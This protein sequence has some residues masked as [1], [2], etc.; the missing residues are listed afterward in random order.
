MSP[1]TVAMATSKRGRPGKFSSAPADWS[2]SEAYRAQG[3]L[4][5]AA[6]TGSANG[7]ARGGGLVVILADS[8]I[9][10]EGDIRVDGSTGQTGGSGG[11][12][13][14]LADSRDVHAS[15]VFSARG[16][17]GVT[18]GG[19]AGG[20][21][22]IDGHAVAVRGAVDL[23][24]GPSTSSPAGSGGSF[25]VDAADAIHLSFSEADLSG[26]GSHSAGGPGG[27]L[28]LTAG[29]SI[30]C[31][32]SIDLSGGSGASGGRGGRAEPKL[33]NLGV[34][35]NACDMTANG[36]NG[37]TGPGG[38]GGA[39]RFTVASELYSDSALS[40]SGGGSIESDA[41]DGGEVT[42]V[43]NGSAE[44]TARFEISG[45]VEANGG[46]AL[47]DSARGGAG[48]LVAIPLFNNG[49][50]GFEV[51]L[52]GY[53]RIDLSGG[54]GSSVGGN[55]GVL[56]INNGLF[57]E[58]PTEDARFGDRGVI[59]YV[60][61]L[62][63]GGAGG[64]GVG[65]DGGTFVVRTAPLGGSSAATALYNYGN[66]ELRG[67]AG[68]SVGGQGG[69]FLVNTA[70]GIFFLG[71]IVT[72]GGDSAGEGGDGSER[73][74]LSTRGPIFFKGGMQSRGGHSLHGDAPAGIGGHLALV[75]SEAVELS[76]GADLSG[77]DNMARLG[78][79]GSGGTFIVFVP[80]KDSMLMGRSVD[81][82]GGL[83]LTEGP[84]GKFHFNDLSILIPEELA[85]T[86]QI[87]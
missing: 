1:Q 87:N 70:D 42:F 77:G 39:L 65:G 31:E 28:E 48:G 40:A 85:M 27:R 16:G 52:L 47:A 50:D 23:V 41:G 53:D 80:S 44:S 51:R 54:D 84:A 12:I 45:D 18:G 4:S 2:P 79:G 21:V 59:S 35:R 66:W 75:S 56:D 26:G 24:G 9:R 49:T 25:R 67:G 73:S 37:A 60:D 57:E 62:A 58:D 76:E 78:E 34:L 43:T 68:E 11:L 13:Q 14:L 29:S 55:G 32:G 38:Q 63:N 5:A 10:H 74:E 15:G 19:G 71:D 69:A 72:S 6:G 86:E 3:Q 46:A 81:L 64:A 83:G 61:I 8:S 7:Q 22:V 82:S 30:H 17:A 36:G 33:R 20:Q